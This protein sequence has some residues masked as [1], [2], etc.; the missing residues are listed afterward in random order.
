MFRSIAAPNTGT[1]EDNPRKYQNHV[2]AFV[3][4]SA[5]YGSDI[6]R[7]NWLRTFEG[8]KMKT[9]KGNLLPWNTL[10]GEFNDAVD[11]S[12]PGMEDATRSNQKLFIAGD[13]RANE[14]PLLI[15]IHT[16]FVREHNNICEQLAEQNPSMSDEEL[17]QSA[18]RKIGAYL[19]NITFNEWLPA[20]GVYM[21][22]YSGYKPEINPQ[23]SNTFSAAAFR[24]GHT[25]INSDVIRMNDDGEEINQGNISL[26][27]AFF[28]PLAI[29]L[30]GGIE[31][32]LRGMAQQESQELDSK[33]IDDLRNFLFP[34]RPFGSLDL[35][36]LNINRGRE[37]GLPDFNSV[38]VELGLPEL[39][40]FQEFTQNDELASLLEEMYGEF[41]KIDPWVGMLA[42]KHIPDAMLGNTL[43]LIIER[44]FQALRDGDRY[45]FENDPAFSAEEVEEIKNTT[46]QKIIMRNADITTMQEQV[47]VAANRDDLPVGPEIS[48]ESLSA[49]AFPNP[50]DGSF[51]VKIYEEELTDITL[52]IFD[53]MGKQIMTET[54]TLREGDNFI[55]VNIPETAPT[56]F[57]NI[58]IQ[59]QPL[60][61]TVLRVVKR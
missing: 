58:L 15:S 6:Q 23:I 44:Q 35:A 60:G 1:G 37:R 21:P 28:N 26:R 57:Y 25:L 49:A 29:N 34:G 2:T 12:A 32:Y 46:F 48:R 4:G 13:V 5:V 41:D 17:Y 45:Y 24:L 55:P 59:K 47:F 18:R 40:S 3:D 52:Q 38:R 10:S 61:Y 16:L 50:S 42:E 43:M 22:L 20:M 31:P 11:P 51:L 30:A 27:D 8:G 54:H 19:Q 39:K 56:G 33:L 9:S 14:N 7:A 36:A 53:A